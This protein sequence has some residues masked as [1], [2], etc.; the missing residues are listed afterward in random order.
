MGVT[1][2]V[3]RFTVQRF[4]V[5]DPEDQ[6]RKGWKFTTPWYGASGFTWRKTFDPPAAVRAGNR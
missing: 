4:K 1:A 5:F 2:Q 3:V 6:T